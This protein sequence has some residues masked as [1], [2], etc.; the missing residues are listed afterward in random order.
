MLIHIQLRGPNAGKLLYT[1][2]HSTTA[3]DFESQMDNYTL[4]TKH[5]KTSTK[6]YT[7]QL[8]AF[9]FTLGAVYK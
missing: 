4:F 7:H 1:L 2:D 6:Q 8:R 5:G 3:Y 9:V